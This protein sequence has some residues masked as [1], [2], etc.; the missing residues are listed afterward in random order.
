MI[1]LPEPVIEFSQ[2][3]VVVKGRSK[4]TV[5]QYEIDL[6]LFLKF[7]KSKRNGLPTE[8]EEFDALT[9]AELDHAF[10]ESVTRSEVLEFLS[11]AAIDRENAARTR[12][13]KLSSLKS[14]YKY[15][16]GT[17]LR[18]KK[19]P[20]ENI[21]SPKLPKAL[22]KFLTE[23]ESIELLQVIDSDT[24]SKTR[25]RDYCIV[26]LFLNCGMRLSELIGIN[27]ADIDRDLTSL[28]VTGK[29]AKER[30]IYLNSACQSALSSY[31]SARDK[32]PAPS[33][34]N[35]LFLSTQHKR[36]SKQMVQTTVYKYLDMAGFANRGLSVHKL[37][38]TA[39]T[40]MYRSGN[41][42]IRVL[43]DILG[44]EQLNTTQIYTHVSDS[45]MK[46][47]M[48]ESPLAD[49]KSRKRKGI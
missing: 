22:P 35:A 13:R 27:L 16:C 5:E 43:K 3:M 36:I 21:D 2:Y 39:A 31:L 42:D 28:R 46:R 30:V 20:T 32:T 18:Y 47:A 23:E 34:K 45:E 8:G 9:I 25:E 37:R 26:T 10:C 19:N 1:Q 40:L 14:F 7:L 15:Y 17:V 38:H 11:F 29:G 41:V 33:H 44:H 6:M 48:T 24:D 4:R 12:A 49:I